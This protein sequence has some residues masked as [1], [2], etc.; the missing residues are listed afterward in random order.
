MLWWQISS[1]SIQAR[2]TCR[3]RLLLLMK[4]G[5]LSDRVDPGVTAVNFHLPASEPNTPESSTLT[6]SKALVT[7]LV[8]IYPAMLHMSL[9]NCFIDKHDTLSDRV[10]PGSAVN[11]H[12]PTSLPKTDHPEIF[13]NPSAT[14]LKIQISS[15]SIQPCPPCRR[16][17]L[18]S[19]EWF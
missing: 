16:R 9:D 4:H 11:F 8:E 3:K 7:D 12:L 6:A 18:G 19:R 15:R 2:S 1:R 14:Q 13:T 17:R 5:T 10:D